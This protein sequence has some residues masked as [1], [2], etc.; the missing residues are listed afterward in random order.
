MHWLRPCPPDG[1]PILGRSDGLG[2][3]VIATGH[4]MMG[5]AMAPITGRLI[6]ELLAGEPT[7]VED[8]I[9]FSPNRFRRGLRR[10]MRA[11]RRAQRDQ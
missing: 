9:P 3:L 11:A 4:T 6:V 2:N 5:L 7:S 10:R 1:L 8:L